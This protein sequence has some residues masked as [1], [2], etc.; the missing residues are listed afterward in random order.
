MNVGGKVG[1]DVALGVQVAVGA[2]TVWLGVGVKEGGE[3]GV[4][5]GGGTGV[6]AAGV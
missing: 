1:V 4:D 5:V 3:I 6:T 2:S